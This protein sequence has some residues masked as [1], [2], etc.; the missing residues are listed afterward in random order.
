MR[1]GPA[2]NVSRRTLLHGLG[3]SM[4]LPWLESL[5]FAAGGGTDTAS[6]PPTRTLITFTG[7]G[8]HSQHWWAKGLA[9]VL[10]LSPMAAF[11]VAPTVWLWAMFLLKLGWAGLLL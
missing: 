7:M 6:Q 1:T 4:A 5:S 8:F 10:V 2:P 9:K 11:Q 3:V